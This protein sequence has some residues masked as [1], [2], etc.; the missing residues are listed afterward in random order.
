M[1]LLC[2]KMCIKYVQTYDVQGKLISCLWVR[3][4][5]SFE[6]MSHRDKWSPS[7]WKQSASSRM[8]QPPYLIRQTLWPTSS[9]NVF[10]I[11]TTDFLSY[12]DP[13]DL[14]IIKRQHFCIFLIKTL[15]VWTM[16]R[17][18]LKKY[19]S[20]DKAG[21]CILIFLFTMCWKVSILCEAESSY[22]VL[23]RRSTGYKFNHPYTNWC[24]L[25]LVSNQG[26]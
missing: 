1:L 17:W 13:L 20:V 15:S 24:K 6:T 7:G 25:T 11:N 14:G 9:Q 12:V 21:C 16:D 5:G 8:N 4:F 18:M 3:D 2:S 19:C 23:L 22:S 26:C 10:S